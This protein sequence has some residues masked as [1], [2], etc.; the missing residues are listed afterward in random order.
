M[1][2]KSGCSRCG[3][4]LTTLQLPSCS[5][6]SITL[7]LFNLEDPR[8]QP[9][10]RPV[11]WAG[12]PD[13]PQGHLAGNMDRPSHRWVNQTFCR[14]LAELC[15]QRQVAHHRES[16]R[17]VSQR[18]LVSGI[19]LLAFHLQLSNVFSKMRSRRA[20][21]CAGPISSPYTL[22]M[23]LALTRQVTSLCRTNKCLR[24]FMVYTGQSACV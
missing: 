17:Q 20:S 21:L 6:V 4:I 18:P 7:Q 1:T 19:A 13:N 11:V 16:E 23:R 24:G 8:R 2:W 3:S 22:R 12:Q 15:K 5:M 14:R 9:V 10:T